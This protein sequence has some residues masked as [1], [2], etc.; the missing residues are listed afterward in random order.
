MRGPAEIESILGP[1]GS[2]A[3]SG[4][5]WV[6]GGGPCSRLA[7]H[8]TVSSLMVIK[9]RQSRT[10]DAVVDA[11]ETTPQKRACGLVDAS[12]RHATT[13]AGLFKWYQPPGWCC[14]GA[15]L[16]PAAVQPMPR[17]ARSTARP[18]TSSTSICPSSTS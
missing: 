8:R 16:R 15:P 4:R 18:I 1:R 9:S 12:P 2:V 6:W 5:G 7:G 3:A 10:D 14:F 13:W 11:C 17:V